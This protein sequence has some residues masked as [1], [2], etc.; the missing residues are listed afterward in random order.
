MGHGQC[1]KD[2]KCMCT[3]ALTAT[4]PAGDKLHAK[5]KS[6]RKCKPA[7]GS[8][9]SSNPPEV[10]SASNADDNNFIAEEQSSTES[11]ETESDI[12]ELTNVEV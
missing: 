8:G 1:S 6:S 4:G 12:Q 10:E 11:S 5:R 9:N 7:I 2:P 3:L